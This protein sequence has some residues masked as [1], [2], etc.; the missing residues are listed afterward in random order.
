MLAN[1]RGREACR[2]AH[3]TA[4]GAG[5]GNQPQ[6]CEGAPPNVPPTLLDRGDKLIE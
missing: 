4:N 2:S 5:I 1:T 6:D 3:R